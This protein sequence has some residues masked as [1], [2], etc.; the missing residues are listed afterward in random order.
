MKDWRRKNPVSSEAGKDAREHAAD[1]HLSRSTATGL[2]LTN[3]QALP[4][5]LDS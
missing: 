2:R 5:R 4:G 3:F 1:R